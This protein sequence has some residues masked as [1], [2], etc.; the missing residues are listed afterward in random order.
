MNIKQF[1]YHN[2]NLA[3]VI[4]G[5]SHAVVIDGGAVSDISAYLKNHHLTL[6]YVLNTHN[7][8]DHTS[9]NKRLLQATEA[10]LIPVNQ[11]ITKKNIQIENL[12]IKIYETPGHTQDS[13]CLHFNDFLITGDTLFNGTVGNCFTNDETSFVRSLQ[14]IRS[15]PDNTIIYAGHDYVL[16]AMQ[17]AKKNGLNKDAVDAF[18]ATYNPKHIYSNLAQ[19][20]AHNIFLRLDSPESIALLQSSGLPH[21]NDTQRFRSLKEI[22]IWE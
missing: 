12:N 2:D 11:L 15:L 4:H 16:P 8:A 3:Y 10:I 14:K 20:K 1:R 22:E 19:E 21:S 6:K 7:H 13:I 9:G 18:L 17:F 5:E